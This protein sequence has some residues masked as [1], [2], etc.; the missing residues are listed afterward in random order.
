MTEF[1]L[2]APVTFIIFNRPDTTK[3]VFEEI[4]KAKPAKFLII[5]DGPRGNRAGEREKCEQTRAIV[6]KIDWEC[7]VLR[8]YSDINMGCKNRVSSG[9]DWVFE[10][11]EESIIL[12]DDCLPEPSFFR[13]CQ[14]L[15]ERY[16]DDKRVMVIS[17]DNMLFDKNNQEYSYYFT[18]YVHIWGWAT[19]RRA[20]NMYDVK[21][22]LWPEIKG[23]GLLEDTVDKFNLIEWEKNF[24]RVYANQFDTWDH[25][26]VLTIWIQSGLSIAP[27]KNL[28]SN[29]GFCENAT[30]T[31]GDSIY[32]NMKTEPMNFPLTHPPY[33]IKNLKNDKLEDLNIF[34]DS[35]YS[36]LGAWAPRLR[37]LKLTI[38]RLTGK[39]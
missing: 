6:E 23:K 10:N 39:L 8:N 36:W 13:Y 38:K 5:A 25:Q 22:K 2:T 21:I 33:M 12:E 17:G 14:E 34:K 37:K 1:K 11:V 15:L 30:H 3:I 9:L 16:R 7:E 31:F 19:W 35:K 29:I 18:K 26:W 32:A 4:R 27:G 24:D 28:I 20:W